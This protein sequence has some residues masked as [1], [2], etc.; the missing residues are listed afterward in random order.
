MD[1]HNLE[2]LNDLFEYCLDAPGFLGGGIERARFWADRRTLD[3]AE[4]ELDQGRLAE[5]RHEFGGRRHTIE[6]PPRCPRA[7]RDA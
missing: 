6:P 5:A 4:Y 3:P 7:I 1:A 2:A